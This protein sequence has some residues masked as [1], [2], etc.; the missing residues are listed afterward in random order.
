MAGRVSTEDGEREGG[1]GEGGGRHIEKCAV[2]GNPQMAVY[3]GSQRGTDGSIFVT[4]N[5]AYGPH[6]R[7][8]APQRTSFDTASHGDSSPSPA[9]AWLMLL[10]QEVQLISAI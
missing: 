5:G 7:A 3:H 8:E 1:R 2:G 6:L 10:W 9:V 4:P